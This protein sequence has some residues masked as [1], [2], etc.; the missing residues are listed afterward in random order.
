MAIADDPWRGDLYLETAGI[1]FDRDGYV[2][3]DAGLGTGVAPASWTALGHESAPLIDRAMDGGMLRGWS[4]GPPRI[5]DL[6]HSPRTGARAYP[7]PI[8]M[9]RMGSAKAATIRKAPATRSRMSW[10]AAT[11]RAN[12]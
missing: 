7:R 11:Q 5:S 12:D 3:V 6:I 10:R 8:R 9:I 4:S 1:E 2:A